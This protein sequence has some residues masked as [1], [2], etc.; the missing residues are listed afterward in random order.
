MWTP[1]QFIQSSTFLWAIQKDMTLVFFCGSYSPASYVLLVGFLWPLC[2][3]V[4]PGTKL[5][6]L[7]S[8]F[9]SVYF[10][11][12]FLKLLFLHFAAFSIFQLHILGPL[13]TFFFLHVL[14]ALHPDLCKSARPQLLTAWSGSRR[15]RRRAPSLFRRKGFL[16]WN[17]RLKIC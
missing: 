13:D 7:L 4:T 14:C 8:P 17:A 16:T 11:W 6:L 12:C 9:P 1:P 15:H 5:E 3:S 2:C 10:A